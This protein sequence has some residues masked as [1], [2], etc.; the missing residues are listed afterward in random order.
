MSVSKTTKAKFEKLMHENL[1]ALGAI[2][3]T[4]KLLGRLDDVMFTP[5]NT[6]G[7]CTPEEGV[8]FM[9]TIHGL[10]SIHVDAEV[11]SSLF[12]VFCRFDEPSNL[13]P[14]IGANMYSGKW[15]H[16][17][18]IHNDVRIIDMLITLRKLQCE[19]V[20]VYSS[21]SSLPIETG[22]SNELIVTLNNV[23]TVF[24]CVSYS[25]EKATSKD[26]KNPRGKMVLCIGD[27]ARI[28]LWNRGCDF[29][30]SIRKI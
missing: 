3:S 28:L 5:K 2:K 11:G 10:L 15:N 9:N 17:F 27:S 8:Y 21:I 4:C 25:I 26:T 16:F 23:V 12:A 1:I 30:I 6:L 7:F 24:T 20:A 18:D 22:H 29:A 13:T 14:D 19:N